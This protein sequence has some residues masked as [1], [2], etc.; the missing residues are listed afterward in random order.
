M[1]RELATTKKSHN[2]AEFRI[3][4]NLSVAEVLVCDDSK[5]LG[6]LNDQY[7]LTVKLD[8][9]SRVFGI[10]YLV[11]NLDIHGDQ[12]AIVVTPTHTCC[13]DDSC[14]RFFLRCFRQQ[15]TALRYFIAFGRFDHNT[16][17][18]WA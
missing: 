18:Q 7:L 15:D 16:V 4:P 8:L 11:V 12:L 14:L 13:Y 1:F 2:D 9:G 3:I 5:N 6:F 17:A 10:K